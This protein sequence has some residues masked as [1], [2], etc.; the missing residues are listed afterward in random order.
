MGLKTIKQLN[1]DFVKS[2]VQADKSNLKMRNKM[3]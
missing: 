3:K 2:L 1:S